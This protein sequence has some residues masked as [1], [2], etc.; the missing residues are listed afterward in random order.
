MGRTATDFPTTWS[1]WV[2][3]LRGPIHG[4]GGLTHEI[5]GV[6]WMGVERL[7]RNDLPSHIPIEPFRWTIERLLD[8]KPTTRIEINE[9]YPKRFS[10]AVFL[11]LEQVPIFEVF[12][13]P[14]TLR[15]VVEGGRAHG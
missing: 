11:V 7:S 3:P 2:M 12:G 5:L 14:K 10:S 8:G 4:Q 6:D 9:K 1:T 15:L 13:R